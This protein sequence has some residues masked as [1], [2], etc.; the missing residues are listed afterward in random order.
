MLK[1]ARKNDCTKE[2]FCNK[3]KNIETGKTEMTDRRKKTN[4]TDRQ[5]L[6]KEQMK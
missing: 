2:R 1:K 6:L 5:F 3:E 4:K